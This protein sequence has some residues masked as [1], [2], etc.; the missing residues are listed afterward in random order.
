MLS[1][2]WNV[3]NI[4]TMVRVAFVPVFVVLL[5]Q[6]TT[7]TRVV[8]CAVFLV[9]A[10]TDRLDGQIARR[11]GLVTNFG[12]IADPIADKLLVGSAIILLSMLGDMPWWATI[13][14]IVRELGVT[15]LRFFMVRRAVMAASNGGKLKT[16]LQII[17][18]SIM[19]FP[20]AGLFGGPFG[21]WI[22][23]LGFVIMLV[24]VAVTVLTSLDY[25]RSA[26]RIARGPTAQRPDEPH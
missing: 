3:P 25:V 26:I 10:Y 17:F 7:V 11:R 6:Y 24:A 12:K 21:G 23:T 4:L 19:V 2:V 13:T 16:V 18:I 15:V 20:W 9:A 1:P 14:I 8:A 5:W 22:Q